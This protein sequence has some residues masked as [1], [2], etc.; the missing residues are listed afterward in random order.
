MKFSRRQFLQVAAGAAALPVASR[1]ART[2]AYPSR[3]V[4]VIVGFPPEGATDISA[5]LI[6]QWLSERLG[7]QFI[8]ENRP[9]AGTN[10]AVQTAVNSPPDG[11]TLLSVT[12]S[13]SS[14]A[15][16]YKSLPF[17]LRRDIAPIAAVTRNALVLEVNPLVP[18]KSVPEF[19]T[20]GRANAGRISAASYG[21]G[22]TGHLAQELFK[23]MTGINML[24]VPY[25]GDALAL[26]D[27]VG[28][29]VQATFSTISASI[30]Y[31]RTGKLRA[32]AV[33]SATRSNALP[34]VPTIGDFVPGYEATSWSGIGAPKATPPEIIESLNREINAGLQDPKLKARFAELG[35]TVVPGSPTDFAKLILEDTKKWAEVIRAANIK[36]E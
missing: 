25:R 5:R 28:G 31:V 14:N 15:T 16:L 19:I 8:I 9:G 7:Q 35:S 24:H 11:Y 23:T 13:N 32:L 21:F 29:Q 36:A 2:Q 27:V 20:Y 10:I 30:A 12:S 3:P 18:V 6:G 17:D 33:T 34:A 22:T 26:T 4:R 1:V